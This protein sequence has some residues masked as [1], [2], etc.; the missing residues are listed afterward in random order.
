MNSKKIVTIIVI[1]VLC[2]AGYKMI[3]SGGGIGLEKSLIATLPEELTNCNWSDDE[4]II[5]YG[6]FEIKNLTVDRQTTDGN[7]KSADCSIEMENEKMKRTIYVN[8]SCVKYDDGSWQVQD[9]SELSEPIAVPKVGPAD[10]E[11]Q[12]VAHITNELGF[13]NFSKT[14]EY[15]DIENGEVIYC[16]SVNETYD[17]FSFTGVVACSYV[18]QQIKQFNGDEYIYYW[19]CSLENNT[20]MTANVLGEWNLVDYDGTTISTRADFFINTISEEDAG[21]FRYSWQTM[22]K[23]GGD[24]SSKYEYTGQFGSY[25]STATCVVSGNDPLDAKCVIDSDRATIEINVKGA[26]G[27]IGGHPCD[28]LIKNN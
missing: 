7:Y 22:K 10:V 27:K 16:Y 26:T 2:I 1:V 8:L 6:D 24:L 19:D 17:Y 3:N 23:V 18:F 11:T 13:E 9:W 25:D 28:E 4:E 20:E 12:S 14:N 15:I 5:I 21:I